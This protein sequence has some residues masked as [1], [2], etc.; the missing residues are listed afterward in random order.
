MCLWTIL[1][2][3]VLAKVR[4]KSEKSVE[5][6]FLKLGEITWTL[7]QLLIV[8]G[9][10]LTIIGGF[11]WSFAE[12]E[13]EEMNLWL[14]S[15]QT[16]YQHKSYNF[17]QST[18]PH[19]AISLPSQPFFS[20]IAMTNNNTTND[21]IL[22][23]NILSQIFKLEQLLFN[24]TFNATKYSNICHIPFKNA[25]YC[26]S[27]RINLFHLFNYTQKYVENQSMINNILSKGNWQIS[28]IETFN[29][30]DYM[31]IWFGQNIWLNPQ[32]I[33][34]N[35]SLNYAKY[36]NF[37]YYFHINDKTD[38]FMSILGDYIMQQITNNP[39]KK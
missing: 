30:A 15:D 9:F 32:N 18:Y 37:V 5:K 29:Y 19:E 2:M 1:A 27:N 31:E 10:V 38:E 14:S 36:I 28:D 8:I 25:T 3:S 16:N 7:P 17:L 4:K 13:Y 23:T 26:S 34:H 6:S 11:G 35:S 20:F 33:E 21:N 39:K 12:I 22:Q 24:F